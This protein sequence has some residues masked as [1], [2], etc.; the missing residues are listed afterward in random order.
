MEAKLEGFATLAELLATCAKAAE[1]AITK[2][3]Q[4][5]GAEYFVDMMRKRAA[6]RSRMRH[7]H[8]LDTITYEQKDGETTI[9][10]TMFYGRLV[11]S[12]HKT[13][14]GYKKKKSSSTKKAYALTASA[15]HK[16]KNVSSVPP[17]R[18][19]KPE[20]DAQK[21]EIIKRIA[22]VYEKEMGL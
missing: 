1:P 16:R 12:G 22:E 11:E 20:F 4:R 8:M 21:D 5:A 6:P 14:L 18:H 3:A 19:M 17:N 2:S 7:A 15:S 9:G 13:V 10:W